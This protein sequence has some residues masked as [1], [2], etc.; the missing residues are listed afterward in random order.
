MKQPQPRKRPRSNVLLCLWFLLHTFRWEYI[1]WYRNGFSPDELVLRPIGELIRMSLLYLRAEPCWSSS[2]FIALQL[3]NATE[4]R[5]V[6][7][8]TETNIEQN[9]RVKVICRGKWVKW[10]IELG[11][12]KGC[13]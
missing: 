2:W 12:E 9:I 3:L 10:G 1:T 5:R 13:P 7:G 6:K 4:T 8:R 11:W